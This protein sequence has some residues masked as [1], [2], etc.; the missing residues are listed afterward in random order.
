MS[1]EGI[2]SCIHRRT[3]GEHMIQASSFDLEIALQKLRKLSMED[4]DLGFEYWHHVCQ[5]LQRAA[6][7]QAEIESLHGE[8]ERCRELLALSSG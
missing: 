8:L 6:G 4:G 1:S 5:L 3:C 2:E 7:R